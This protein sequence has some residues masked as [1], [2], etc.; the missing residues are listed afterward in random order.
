MV[1]ERSSRNITSIGD[2][3]KTGVGDTV[4]KSVGAELE[5]GVVGERVGLPVVG[6]LVVGAV[7]GNS[8]IGV[9]VGNA[10]GAKVAQHVCGQ[11]IWTSGSSRHRC[12]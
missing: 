11:R 8:V 9:S 5:G 7:L 3:Q 4:G 10:V 2:L 1:S 12:R 6:V